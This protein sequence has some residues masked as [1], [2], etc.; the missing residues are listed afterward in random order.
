[1][2]PLKAEQSPCAVITPP[3]IS[4]LT[5]FAHIHL[6]DHHFGGVVMYRYSG[7]TRK[8]VIEMNVDKK[9]G[10]MDMLVGITIEQEDCSTFKRITP[11]SCKEQQLIVIDLLSGTHYNN[12]YINCCKRVCLVHKGLIKKD[13]VSTFGVIVGRADTPIKTVKLPNNFTLKVLV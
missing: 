11:H 1:M 13:A 10:H 5:F 4:H 8:I 3:D 12:Q 7:V 6:N 2:I 9:G